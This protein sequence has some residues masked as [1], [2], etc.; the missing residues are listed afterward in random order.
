MAREKHHVFSARMTEEG[1]RVLNELR[2]QRN[3]GWDE[4]VIEAVCA[5][6]GLDTAVMALP[7]QVKPDKLQPKD[8]RTGNAKSKKKGETDGKDNRQLSD[9]KTQV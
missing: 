2:E 6:Y 3:V 8:R 5:H 1:L 4:L 9:Q 7:Q